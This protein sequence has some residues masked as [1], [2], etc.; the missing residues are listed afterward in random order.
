MILSLGSN[1]RG[2]LIIIMGSPWKG[3]T[4]FLSQ[5]SVDMPQDY[6]GI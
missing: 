4:L 3:D 2:G 1:P 5:I 6:C